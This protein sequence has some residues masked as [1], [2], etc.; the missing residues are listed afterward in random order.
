MLGETRVF[1]QTQKQNANTITQEVAITFSP[2]SLYASRTQWGGTSV[3][4]RQFVLGVAH[5]SF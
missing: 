1:P 2:M 5:E 4:H 3:V